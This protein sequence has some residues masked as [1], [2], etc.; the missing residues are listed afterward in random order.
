MRD[1]GTSC[2]RDVLSDALQKTR[3]GEF[4]TKETT[5]VNAIV[6]SFSMSTVRWQQYVKLKAC[7]IILFCFLNTQCFVFSFFFIFILRLSVQQLL[8]NTVS[9]KTIFCSLIARV[10]KEL[11]WNFSLK[12]SQGRDTISASWTV[13][14]L[15]WHHVWQLVALTK[16][17][18]NFLFPNLSYGCKWYKPLFAPQ[19]PSK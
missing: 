9:S 5:L 6:T 16:V 18:C 1:Q 12:I 13:W 15:T 19:A 11:R 3:A 7:G 17:T 14:H 4:S 8:F 2:Y 10:T